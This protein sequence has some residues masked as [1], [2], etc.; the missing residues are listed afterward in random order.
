MQNNNKALHTALGVLALVISFVTYLMTVQPTV[1]F[2]D[3]GE[4]TAAAVGQQVPHPPGAPLFLMLG[5]LFHLL[6]FGDPGWR[7]NLVSV[8]ASA[9]TIL[10]LYLITV[11]VIRNFFDGDLNEFGNALLVYGSGFIGALTFAFSDTF[12]FNAVESEVY[13]ASQV[14]VALIVWL[15]MVWT[16]KA[17]QPGHEKYLLLIA[18]IIGLSIGVHLLSILTIF[19][20][21]LLIYLRKYKFSIG[22][23][24]LTLLIGLATFFVVY[25]LIIMKLPALFAGNFPLKTEA[26]EWLIE[27][28]MFFTLFGIGILILAGYGVYYG[29]KTKHH[30]MGLLCSSFL[31]IV[32]GYSSYTHIMIRAN[33]NPP[34]NEN[35]P[36]NFDKLV[37][38]LG[39][40]QYGDAPRWPRRYQTEQ[41]FVERYQKFGKWT[42]PPYKTVTK[43]DGTQFQVPNYGAW[44]TDLGAELGY[45]WG[46][47]VKHM[48]LRYFAWNF[49]GRISDVQDSPSYSPVTSKT[50]V[51][52]WNHKN[53][54]ASHFPVN[55]WALPFLLGC[56]GL[57]FQFMRDK[58]MAWVYLVLF[59]MT[60][61]LA[62]IQQ[63]QQDPQPRERDYFYVGS[64]MIWAMWVGLGSFAI[65]ER[66]R[67]SVPAMGG[68]LAAV[69]LVVPVNMAYQGWFIHSRAGNYL[70]FDYAYNILQSLEKDAI[71][72]TNGDNDTFPVWYL[73]DVAGVRRD[74]RVVNLSLGQT[75]WYIEQL[76]NQEPYGA[77]RLP[78][79]FS[80]ESLTVKENDPKAL[81]YDFGP[82]RIVNIDIDPAVMAKFTSDSALLRN[83][84]MTWT[85]KGRMMRQ[86]ER[87]NPMYLFGVQHK[88]VFDIINQTKMKR[89]IYFST[90]VGDPSWADEY[91]GLDNYLRLEGMAYRVCPSPQTSAIGEG[92]NDE[93]MTASLVKTRDGDDFSTEPAYGLKFRNLNTPTVYYDDVHRGYLSNYRNIF[94]RYATWLLYEKKDSVRAVA[95]IRRMNELISPE[96]FSMPISLEYNMMKMLESAGA[97]KDAEETAA[98]LLKTCEIL[99]KKPALRAWEPQM[100]NNIVPE[101]MAGEVSAVLGR[102][103]DAA[104]YYR[105]F[106]RG[107]AQDPL[108]N[109]MIDEL[110]IQKLERAKDYEGALKA[111][112]ALESKYPV[113]APDQ[114]MQQAA[115][116][117][118]RRIMQLQIRLGRA[119]QMI[120]AA[121]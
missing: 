34:M 95:M 86:D 57:V 44:K 26:E 17:D 60:G 88:L 27:D 90:S 104:N 16:E 46:Y 61:V 43:K 50:D 39:R 28:S 37:S 8:V 68:A 83:P 94:Y 2:W 116:E 89:P 4:F 25:N 7:V 31:L 64:F 85:Y 32:L 114:R 12:W 76:K 75:Q 6:P 120:T 111:A 47:Q 117:L 36:E 70:A 100:N 54:Y 10:L 11:K 101:R 97:Q 82:A 24:I 9:V 48:Y 56:I 115:M 109:F 84:V 58:K 105:Q 106:A 69:V 23:F 18:Y 51:E 63:N 14:F 113:N 102:Y 71:V 74:V 110:Q 20:L 118:Q 52:Q 80:D 65:L 38:Y 99:I 41:R 79:S 13:A 3:C 62:A 72:F 121:Q 49:I 29:R 108:L 40:E 1:P 103:D 42:R 81:T 19:S 92:V 53:G 93:V 77:K 33:S 59:L 119:P 91:I 112:L 21:V 35:K 66:L 98:R 96:L 67:K 45:L 22:T 87:G 107:S 55:F 15:M 73:Q 5:K 30:V 78:L